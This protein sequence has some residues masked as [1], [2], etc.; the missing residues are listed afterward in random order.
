MA[1]TSQQLKEAAHDLTSTKSPVLE[2]YEKDRQALI[3]EENEHRTGNKPLTPYQ[4][5]RQ[6]RLTLW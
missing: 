6:S 3:T 2:R 1:L 4:E 5:G